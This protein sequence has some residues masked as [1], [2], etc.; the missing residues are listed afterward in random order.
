MPRPAHP[1][2][3]GDDLPL[4]RDGAV[5]ARR[6]A[7]RRGF[8][9]H[10]PLLPGGSDHILNKVMRVGYGGIRHVLEIYI[11]LTVP[12]ELSGLIVD[13]RDAE[14]KVKVKVKVKAKANLEIRPAQVC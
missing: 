4:P 1:G 12:E 13:R 5:A 2:H 11:Q 3:L 9:D 7:A 10:G 14:V 8:P 6:H